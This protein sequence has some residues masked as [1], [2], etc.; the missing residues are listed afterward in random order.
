MTNEPQKPP[1]K[2]PK[3]SNLYRPPERGAHP[4]VSDDDLEA[5]RSGPTGDPGKQPKE[6]APKM[7]RGG[8]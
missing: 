8:R 7:P 1:K 5:W 3:R 6:K 4:P 2:L